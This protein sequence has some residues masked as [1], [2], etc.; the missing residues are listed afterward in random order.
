MGKK[1]ISLEGLDGSGKTTQS[2]LLCG[3]LKGRGI[4]FRHVSFPNYAEPYS[5]PVRMY[6]GGAF[7]G[8]PGDVNAY[9]ASSF[10]A[11]DRFASF[12]SDWK[13]DYESG[14]PILADRYTT[15]NIVYQLPK[16]PKEEWPGFVEWLQDYEYTKL[17]LPRPD[18]TIYLDMPAEVS[19][20]LL[21]IRYN[22][23]ETK[24]DI[25]E[26]D[27]AYL[28]SCRESAVYAAGL[29]GWRV[30]DC[31]ESGKPK[32]IGRIHD[33]IMQILSEELSF[34]V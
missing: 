33:E 17:R 25:H 22:G 12:A 21:G 6:L 19:R 32:P 34:H 1:L 11:V 13:K 5:A 23:D 10:F 28:S 29:L 31:A 2:E 20:E 15:S 24:K 4:N 3:D 8:G 30:V 14:T 7:G 16:L 9:A 26:R 27:G 18:L